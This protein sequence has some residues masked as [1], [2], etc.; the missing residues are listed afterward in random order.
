MNNNIDWDDLQEGPTWEEVFADIPT[1]PG[2]EAEQQ[3]H[4]ELRQKGDAMTEEEEGELNELF[5][6]IY[7]HVVAEMK[8]RARRA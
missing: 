3:R 7:P 1:A 6:T 5:Y 8:R 2:T 4:K